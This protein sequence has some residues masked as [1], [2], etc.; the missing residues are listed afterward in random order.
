[1]RFF[2]CCSG[3][4]PLPTTG[5]S[6]LKPRYQLLMSVVWGNW[7]PRLSKNFLTSSE[8]SASARNST[9]QSGRSISG[10]SR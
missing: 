3:V 6:Q 5:S 9:P 8:S 1:M 10:T 4:S 2:N 7:K